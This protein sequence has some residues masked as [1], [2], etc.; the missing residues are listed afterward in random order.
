M[1]IKIRRVPSSFSHWQW[2]KRDGETEN[3]GIWKKK[4]EGTE[5]TD[6]HKQKGAEGGKQGGR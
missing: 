1:M 4:Q 3:M 5:M 2:L 6:G